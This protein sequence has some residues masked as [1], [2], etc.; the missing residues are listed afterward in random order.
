MTEIKH[1]Q[2]FMVD[3]KTLGKII[4][5]AKI[6]K[7]ETVVEIGPGTGNLS[8]K[9]NCKKLILIEIDP[10][11]AKDLE[12]LKLKCQKFSTSFELVAESQ[13]YSRKRKISEHAQKP[14]R[15]TGHVSCA[16]APDIPPVYDGRFLTNAEILKGNALDIIPHLEFD[17]L[18]SNLPY[19]IC[20]PLMHKLFARDFK[21]AILTVPKSF[22]ERIIEKKSKLGIYADAFL[23][24]K[25]IVPVEK[26]AFSPPPDTDSVIIEIKPKKI[27]KKDKLI[28]ELYFQRDKKLK[29]ALREYLVKTNSMTKN[30]AREKME[31]F[32][33]PDAILDKIINNLSFDELLGIISK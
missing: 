12:K 4:K 6:G 29:N 22:Y 5:A 24:T 3:E 27:L 14:P 33:I 28:C 21:S 23:K 1:D 16:S 11:F 30:E 25:L 32:K 10:D 26:Q 13:S 19:Q 17:K 20:E 18:V 8:K 31:E 15:W 2:H 9:I 7:D